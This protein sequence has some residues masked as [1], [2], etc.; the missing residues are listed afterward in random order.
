MQYPREKKDGAFKLSEHIFGYVEL[1]QKRLCL[2]KFVISVFY[3]ILGTEHGIKFQLSG[4]QEGSKTKS[5]GS[6]HIQIFKKVYV[7]YPRE[8]KDG[9][10]KLSEHIIGYVELNQKRLCLSKFVISVFYDILGTEHG[11]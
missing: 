6:I 9:A 8:K 11:S 5:K 10:F 4:K 1:N 3:D 2:S 7:Q